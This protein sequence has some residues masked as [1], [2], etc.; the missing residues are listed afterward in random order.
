MLTNRC[1]H[2]VTPST[3]AAR[4]LAPSTVLL[5]LILVISPAYAG[6]RSAGVNARLDALRAPILFE[7]NRGQADATVKFVAR[8]PGYILAISNTEAVMSIRP[9]RMTSKPAFGAQLNRRDASVAPLQE[10]DGAQLR[11]RILR[12]DRVAQATGVEKSEGVVNYYRGNDPKHWLSGVPTF[13]K[14]RF[15]RVYEG[16]DLLYYGT[17]GRLEYDFVVQPG[18]DPDRI[19]VAFEGM[20][21]MAVD[22]GGDLVLTTSAGPVRWRKPVVY[23]NVAG[24]RVHIAGSYVLQ[25]N[26]EVGFRL[27]RYDTTKPLV[28]DPVLVYSTLLGGGGFDIGMSVKVDK[29]GNTYL[30]GYTE[31]ANFPLSGSAAQAMHGGSALYKTVDGGQSW[32]PSGA[33]LVASY[34]SALVFYPGS[35]NVIYAGCDTGV[36]RSTD[37]GGSWVSMSNGLPAR[38]LI[39][40][41]AI[42]PTNPSTLYAGGSAGMFKSTNGGA[43]WATITNGLPGFTNSFP[44]VDAIVVDTQ[45]PSNVYLGFGGY[46]GIYKSTNGGATWTSANTG[47]GLYYFNGGSLRM[48]PASPNVL[49]VADEGGIYITTD[50]AGHWNLTNTGIPGPYY[51]IED[52]VMS[53]GNPAVL[54]AHNALNNDQGLYLSTN[55]GASWSVIGQGLGYYY[56][57]LCNS[58]TQNNVL[59]AAAFENGQGVTKSV[60]GG[61]TW[62]SVSTGL[63]KYYD[64]Y[65]Y[66]NF[67]SLAISPVDANTVYSGPIL[68]EDGFVT[69]FSPAGKLVY[70]TFLGGSA[71]DEARGVAVDASGNA[72]V[73]GST[74]SEDFPTTSGC[75]QPDLKGVG[76]DGGDAFVTKLDPTGRLVYS[77]FLGGKDSDT[78]QSIAVDSA[79]NAVVAG[80]TYS[81]D[82]PATAGAYNT[83]F[84]YGVFVTKLNASGTG[85]VFSTAI[86]PGTVSAVAL[87]AAGNVFVAGTANSSSFPTTAGVVQPSYGGGYGDAFASQ[88]NA[89]GAALIYSTFLGGSSYD[90]CRGLAIDGTGNAYVSG[91]TLSADYPVTRGAFRTTQNGN[92]DTFVTKLNPTATKRV[93]ST[94]IGGVDTFN[95]GIAVGSDNMAC[96]TGSVYSDFPVTSNAIQPHWNPGRNAAYIAKLNGTGSALVY[97]SYLAGYGEDYAQAIVVDSYKRIYVTG[98]ADGAWPTTPNAFQPDF[99]G[100]ENAF[101]TVISLDPIALS[102]LTVAPA[103]IMGPLT[104]KGTV[105]LTSPAA[106]DTIVHLSSSIA[107]A[108][109]PNTVT[110]PSGTTSASFVINTVA[111]SQTVNGTITATLGGSSKAAL[112]AVRPIGVKSLTVIPNPLAGGDNAGGV[113][114]LEAKAVPGDITVQLSSDNPG[115]ANPDQSSIK[116]T[117]GKSSAVFTLSTQPVSAPTSVTI[118]ATANG[119]TKTYV[120][121]ITP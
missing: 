57:F 77:T 16:V 44:S 76:N 85:L 114:T 68:G 3:V 26:H 82:F 12:A 35:A 52:L 9:R 83:K 19:A 38:P 78:G 28:I 46:L 116:V 40:S 93:Y 110:V 30:A 4:L 1:L 100:Y 79:G 101:L 2:T 105:T 11:M 39:A 102:A 49:Y 59:Y 70:S 75:L 90:L 54:F 6:D 81:V 14:I 74:Y 62:S 88:L 103:I 60:D 109:V 10:S 64:P 33:G 111:V 89:T 107:Q 91:W 47:L 31:S 63:P 23:Q 29:S 73:T 22:G 53:P 86:G 41:L 18:A 37:A 32:Q 34:V 58:A 113:V 112:L 61:A 48:N 24:H 55:S 21:G 20:R 98:L 117:S 104:A 80:F 17:D 7:E 97:G 71:A 96:I 108:I 72:Y 67:T 87:N 51:N 92:F 45:N 119:V 118:S 121:K 65:D 115:V 50:G 8:S 66:L 99:P 69:K 25:Q 42:D 36:F 84:G 5:T 94:F 13:S 15:V 95:T 43:S 120:L 106:G 27:A 56:G